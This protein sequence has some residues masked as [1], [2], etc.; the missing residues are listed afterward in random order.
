M[1]EGK[2]SAGGIFSA[3]I[4]MVLINERIRIDGF[5]KKLISKLK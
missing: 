2:W 1:Y 4:I 5:K 3:L